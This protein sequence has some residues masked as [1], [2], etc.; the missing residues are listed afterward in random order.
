MLSAHDE[1]D[2][3]SKV[4][5]IE[6]LHDLYIFGINGFVVCFHIHVDNSVQDKVI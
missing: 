2:I 4:T 3:S 1:R 6:C 5:Q